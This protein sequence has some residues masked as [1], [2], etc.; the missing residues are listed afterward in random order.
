MRKLADRIESSPASIYL[1]FDRREQIAR[2]LSAAGYAQLLDRLTTA[3]TSPDPIERLTSVGL[4]YVAFGLEHPETYR[5]IFMGD[6]GYMTTVLAEKPTNSP[7]HRA[8]TLLRAPAKPRNAPRI[9][10]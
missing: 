8:F 9:T 1:H 5:L 3:A 6:S 10:L 2:E 4:T 7:A